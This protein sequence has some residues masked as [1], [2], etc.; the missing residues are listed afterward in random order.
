MSEI[1]AQFQNLPLARYRIVLHTATAAILPAIIGSTLRGAFGHALKAISCCVPHQ[2]CKICFLSEVCLYTTVFEPTAPKLKDAPRPFIFEPPIPPLTN[3]LS[4]NSTLK[5]LISE[6]GKIS[7]DLIL[8]GE[9][10]RKMPYFIYALELMARHGLGAERQPFAVSEVFTINSDDSPELIYAS[11]QLK[12]LP[13]RTSNLGEQVETVLAKI[14]PSENLRI[15]F[16]TPLRINRQRQILEKVSFTEFFKQCSLRIKFLS[17]NYGQP[18]EYDYQTLMTKTEN[19]RI[20]SENLWRHNFQRWTN[21]RSRHEP[22]DGM[23]GKIEYGGD[24]LKEFLPFVI[25]GSIL[26]IGNSTSFGLGQFKID[27]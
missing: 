22:L 21:R 19:I 1:P 23:L 15:S 5:L 7:F 20:V 10:I 4:Q 6:N 9:A 17:E 2:D 11:G 3:E 27:A 13:H 25:A 26:H 12:V 18:V 24:S 16:P 14:T 8:I